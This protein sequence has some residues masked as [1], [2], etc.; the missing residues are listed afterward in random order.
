M[1]LT[2]QAHNVE[3]TEWLEQYVDKKIGRLDWYLPDID[4]AN[5]ELREEKTRSAADRA[6]APG[7]HSQPS[8]HLAG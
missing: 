5:V 7:H 4:E 8:H 2:I 6:V 3:L 1:K